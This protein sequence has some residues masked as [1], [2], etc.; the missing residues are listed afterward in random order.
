MAC[1]FMVSW[2]DLR[3][4]NTFAQLPAVFYSRL[5]PAPYAENYLVAINPAAAQLL[6]LDI[7]ARSL[8]ADQL[9]GLD[10]PS[11]CEPLAMLYAGHQF[12]SYVPQLGDG[13]A[14]VLGDVYGADGALWELQLKGAGPTPYS[15]RGDGRAVLRSSIR[16]FLGCEA[17]H[18][19]GVPTTRALSITGSDEPVYREQVET[20]ATVLRFAP[21]HVRFGSFEVHYYRNQHANIK[22]LADYIIA[23]HYPEIAVHPQPYLEFLSH[24]IA[25]TA[26]LIAQWQAVGFTHGVMNS[27]NMSILGLTMDYGPFGF[28]DAYNPGYNCNHSDSGGRYS[29]DQQPSIGL[30]NLA[31]L[32]QTLIPL[33]SVEDAKAA[34]ARYEEVFDAHYFALMT[35]KLGLVQADDEARALVTTLLEIMAKNNV[36]YTLFLRRLGGFSSVSQDRNAELRDMFLDREAFDAWAGRYAARLMRTNCDAAARKRRMLGVNPKYVLRNYMAQSAIE[37]A[38]QKDFS[39]V[40]ALLRVLQQPFAEHPAYAHYADYPPAWAEQIELSCSS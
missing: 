29:F 11:T 14:L 37:K 36:D 2:K 23:R 3:F 32:A 17:M 31:C 35:A 39:E 16:E 13:R 1:V 12:G 27:D 9:A 34:L 5:A 28:M 21:T 7:D 10:L 25:R 8:S 22:I 4:V 24:V 6:N 20:A 18:G 33:I 15:R 30:W 26:R 38:Q 19:L 40:E